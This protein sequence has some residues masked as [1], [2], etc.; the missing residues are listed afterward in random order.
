MR[1]ENFSIRFEPPTDSAKPFEYPIRVE[2][3]AGGC[4]SV[5]TFP[6]QLIRE[7]DDTL[8]QI[9]SQ[10]LGDRSR[11]LTTR[12]TAKAE[13]DPTEIGTQLFEAVFQDDV[14]SLFQNSKG[15]VDATGDGLRIRLV[16]DPK[17][18]ELATI[19]RLPWELMCASMVTDRFLALSKRTPIVRFLDVPISNAPLELSPPF[20][21]LVAMS[22]PKI[23]DNDLLDLAKERKRI[24]ESWGLRSDVQ[25]D[26]LENTT[27]ENLQR[28]LGDKDYHVLHFMGHGDFDANTGTGVLVLEHN[29]GTPDLASGQAIGT[30]LADEPTLRLVFLNACNTAQANT[31]PDLDPFTGVASALVAAGVPSVIA[32]QYPISDKAAITFSEKVYEL[33][34]QCLPLDIVVSEARKSLDQ[35]QQAIQGMEWSTPA[36]FM[37]S[38]DGIIFESVFRARMPLQGVEKDS[39]KWLRS[40]VHKTWIKQKLDKDIPMKPPIELDKELA[41]YALQRQSSEESGESIPAGKAIG[42]LFDEKNRSLLILGEPGHGKTIALLALAQYLLERFERDP[43]ETEP[44]P[45][46]LNLSTWGRSKLSLVK[47]AAREVLEK[48]HVS[49]TMCEDWITQGRIVLLLDGLDALDLDA[50]ANCIQAINDFSREQIRSG[51]FHGLAICC[52]FDEYKKLTS[53]LNVQNAVKLHP[54]SEDQI[55]LYIELC[56]EKMAGLQACLDSDPLLSEDAKIPLILGMMSIAYELSPEKFSEISDEVEDLTGQQERKELITQAYLDRVFEPR[57]EREEQRLFSADDDRTEPQSR[58]KITF[59]RQEIVRHLSWL[60][61]GMKQSK[62]SMFLIE[63]LQPSWCANHW[64]R[65]LNLTIYSLAMGFY[66]AALLAILWSVSSHVD[67]PREKTAA[68]AAERADLNPN[69]PKPVGL[70]ERTVPSPTSAEGSEKDLLVEDPAFVDNDAYGVFSIEPYRSAISAHRWWFIATPIVIFFWTLWEGFQRKAVTQLFNRPDDWKWSIVYTGTHYLIVAAAYFLIW[71]AIWLV[72]KKLTGNWDDHYWMS[73]P[74]QGS[75]SVTAVYAFRGPPP[76]TSNYVGTQEKLLWSWKWCAIGLVFGMALGAVLALVT[77]SINKRFTPGF[78]MPLWA[79]VGFL[80]GGFRMRPARTKM[81]P[82]EG[83][84]LSLHNATRAGTVIGGVI[85]VALLAIFMGSFAFYVEFGESELTVTPYE[86][87]WSMENFMNKC[88]PVILL[89]IVTTMVSF[90]WFGGINVIR[91]YALRLT[92][93]LTKQLPL[94]IADLC[95]QASEHILLQKVGGGYIFRN[96]L[97][98]D[99]FESLRVAKRDQSDHSN[100]PDSAPSAP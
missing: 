19:S 80:F 90:L 21:I 20:R 27:R 11:A 72:I 26:F 1:Y 28:V 49:D 98:K 47:W 37:R 17:E 43:T 100:W 86:H 51:R 41:P 31:N 61:K 55:R 99:Y 13:V 39:Y 50:R 35:A 97:L 91:H 29:D 9:S 14:E 23:K 68:L 42:S 79:V 58:K 44:L 40:E 65:F 12:R 63:S 7:L 46:F 87:G 25:V 32:M 34:P 85:A 8:K 10:V 95:D 16:I 36:L 30:L 5:A 45:V 3:P 2:S 89:S 53:R 54:L 18:P 94:Q 66:I 57:E 84:L 82:N 96:H 56:G 15:R 4:S 64:Q 71:N 83:I 69:E 59:E 52:R 78:A 76:S 73:H 88:W 93:L 6:P 74:F 62:Q 67:P 33:L 70:A 75:I 38:D 24:E 60:A 77:M 92:L 22:N 48:H 81:R